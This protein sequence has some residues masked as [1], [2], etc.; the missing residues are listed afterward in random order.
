MTGKQEAG[1]E[2]PV[3]EETGGPAVR[4][5]ISGDAHLRSCINAGSLAA[6]ITGDL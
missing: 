4:R 5:S 6:R 2:R 1:K 3:S